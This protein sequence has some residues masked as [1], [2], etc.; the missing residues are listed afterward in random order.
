MADID[1]TGKIY[2]D[3]AEWTKFLEIQSRGAVPKGVEVA[4]GLPKW[5][6]EGIVVE[7]A[8]SSM[9]HPTDWAVTPEFL[10]GHK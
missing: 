6:E 7:F 1:G 4:F 3:M 8:Y 10:K 5:D 9:C 2:I